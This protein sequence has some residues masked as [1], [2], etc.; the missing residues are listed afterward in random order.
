VTDEKE[1]GC[2]DQEKERLLGVEEEED[3]EDIGRQLIQRM[4]MGCN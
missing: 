2:S 3:E 1:R 4:E